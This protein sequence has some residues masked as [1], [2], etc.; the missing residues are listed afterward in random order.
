MQNYKTV[1][2]KAVA[3]CGATEFCEILRTDND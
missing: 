1:D 3:S 2:R